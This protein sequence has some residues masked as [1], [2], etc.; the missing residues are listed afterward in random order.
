M[1]TAYLPRSLWK[2]RTR[3]ESWGAQVVRRASRKYNSKEKAQP[4]VQL[5]RKEL[6][7]FIF[8]LPSIH[9]NSEGVI[10]C[11]SKHPSPIA[12]S[13]SSAAKP[14]SWGTN[15]SLGRFFSVGFR[16][17]PPSIVVSLLQTT[18]H[19]THTTPS[20]GRLGILWEPPNVFLDA[21]GV[22][23]KCFRPAP[24]S[25]QLAWTESTPEDSPRPITCCCPFEYSRRGVE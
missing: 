25:S 7:P 24:S 10:F 19:C 9:V 16:L 14:G 1:T 23:L 2:S 3:Q 13:T 18:L 15:P 6:S 12:C 17:P 21:S 4:V 22:S 5:S 8:N 11:S 20:A